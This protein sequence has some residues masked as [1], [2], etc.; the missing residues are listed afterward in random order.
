VGNGDESLLSAFPPVSYERWREQVEAGLKGADFGRRLVTRT[1]EGIEVQP[2][3]TRADWPSEEDAGG[4]PGAPPYRRGAEAVGRMGE[5]WDLRPRHDNPDL[6]AAATELAHDTSRGAGSLW[7]V[8][9]DG[10]EGGPAGLPV[11]DAASL[12][13]L[14]ADV[15]LDR[16]RI[17]LDAGGRAPAASAALFAVAR[18][19][20]VDL[21]SLQAW[22]NCDPLGALSRSGALPCSLDAAR[23][24]LGEL[25]SFCA[26]SAPGV[27]TATVSTTGYHDAGA[28][29][30]QELAYALATGVTYLRWLT[31]AG[32]TLEQAGG[33]LAFSVSVGGDF[34]MEMAKLRALRQCW[35]AVMQA[36][37]AETDA[38]RCVIHATTSTRTKT[39]RDPWVNM[40][41]ETTEA[42]SAAS[43]GADAITTGGFD[44][45]LGVSDALGR[46][47]AFNTQ[48]I[49]DEEAHVTQ[50][51]DPAGGS[52]Y[53]ERLTDELAGAAWA[54]MQSI[55]REGGMAEALT[56]GRVAEQIAQVAA[57]RQADLAKR[58][59]AITGVSEFAN[60]DERPLERPARERVTVEP[61]GGSSVDLGGAAGGRRVAAAVDAAADGAGIGEITGALA[62]ESAP[63]TADA[64]PVRRHADA[65]ERLRDACDRAVAGGQPPPAVFSCNLG[66]IPKHK[67]RAQFAL[68]FLNAGG[69]QVPENDG[70]VDAATAAAAFADS[71]ASIA[72]ICGTDEQYA[73]WVAQVTPEL[74]KR[75]A[76][77]I[78]L[79]GRPGDAEQAFRDAGVTDFIYMGCD[80]VRT[81]EELLAAVGVKP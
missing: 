53:V 12:G 69:F 26:E 46:R 81:L 71:G 65:F 58:K 8:I 68:G 51:A 52:W 32:L 36:C 34:F 7:L 40:L 66:P 23:E 57:A 77:R 63:A 78:V 72:V 30:V 76:R 9:D 42:F 2:L 37:G 13:A 29:A 1:H 20:R 73:E 31:D 15:P 59:L 22:L 33:Q 49:L 19:R 25:A 28:N 11:K 67:A 79:A 16:V 24:Q 47:V 64:L 60:V 4:F 45:L 21:A 75:G 6:N 41:R 70:F 17:S 10:A 61:S 3:Y 80:V 54:L 35:D 38:R 18:E 43:G 5:R 14:L 27:R 48:V 44:R 39:R 56:S 62:G 50:V 74:Q 55:E